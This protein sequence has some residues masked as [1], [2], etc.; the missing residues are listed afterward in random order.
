MAEV[1]KATKKT[2]TKTATKTAAKKKTTGLSALGAR[3]LVKPIVS[4]KAAQ[5]S[6]RDVI[7]FRV[8][9]QA[10]RV[11]VRQAFKEVYGVTPVRVNMVNSRGKNVRFGKSVGKRSDS[12]KALIFLP[13]GTNVDVFEG[14]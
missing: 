10:N 1:K 11:E 12:K 6:T 2:V 13:K 9:K 8:H 7:A 5:L 4:E 14:V 3:I